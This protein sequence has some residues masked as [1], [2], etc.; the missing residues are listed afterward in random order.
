MMDWSSLFT[1]WFCLLAM[2]AFF[3]GM[4]IGAVLQTFSGRRE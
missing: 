3:C 1:P 2:F 4:L